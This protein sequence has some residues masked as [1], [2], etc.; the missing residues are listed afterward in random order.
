VQ[1]AFGQLPDFHRGSLEQQQAGEPV[2]GAP[3]SPPETLAT[4]GDYDS[5][6]A[7]QAEVATQPPSP[8]LEQRFD[9][10]EKQWAKFQAAEAKKKDETAAK[11]T[12]RMGGQ[13]QID[14]L[15]FSQDDASRA[16]VGDVQDAFDF[17]RARLTAQGEAFDVFNYAIGFDFALGTANNGRPQFLD[18][19]VGVKDLP[20]VNNLRVGHFFEP[21]SL[22][23]LTPN[24]YNTFLERSLADTFAPARNLGIMAFDQFQNENGT[25]ALG[26][27]RSNSDNF[28]DDAGDQEGQALTGRLTWLP[29]YDEASDG[30]GYWHL[31]TAYSFRQAADGIV[32]F[33]SRPE[34]V[35]RS[36]SENI[37]V[38][39]FVDTGNLAAHNNQL[40]GLESV[41]TWG[42]F[43]VQGEYMFV[44][45]DRT[46]GDNVTFSA[47]YVYASYFLTGEHR[48]YNRKLGFMDRVIPFENFF[49]VR[50]NDGLVCNGWGAWEVAARLSRIDLTQADVAGGDL[51]D[52]T[53]SLNWY[54]TPYHRVK[55]EYIQAN[56]DRAPFGSTDTGIFGIRF[57]TDF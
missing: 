35:G 27:F 26:T 19:F 38:P 21:F 2:A 28:G 37:S 23:R 3:S 46:T 32:R 13:L 9:T 15:W 1:L 12:F 54:L 5:L 25:W 55:W 7:V 31:G 52:F 53:V 45:V 22:E 16:A 30:R 49:R 47:G 14:S 42:A 18:V 43:S 11:P 34:A 8:G 20:L 24:R 4:P 39:F 6:L 40:Y 33:R 17:R 36:E 50:T 29:W 44:P 48:P 41:F 57:D 10:L 56:L 51:T